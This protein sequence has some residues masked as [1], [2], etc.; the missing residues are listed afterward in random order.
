MR[1]IRTLFFIAMLFSVVACSSFDIDADNVK[2]INIF[3]LND[4]V[5]QENE[6]SS[7]LED[8]VK[9][10]VDAINSSSEVSGD[11]DYPQPHYQMDLSL[12]EGDELSFYLWLEDSRTGTIAT[13]EDTATVYNLKMSPTNKLREILNI[14]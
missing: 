1:I 8:D 10:V 12:S 6:F 14:D 2:E 11:V 13:L 5:K 9:I 3:T 7:V 4:E